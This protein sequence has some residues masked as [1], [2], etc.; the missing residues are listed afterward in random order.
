MQVHEES[1][2]IADQLF[3]RAAMGRKDLILDGTLKTESVPELEND[4]PTNGALGRIN[5]LKA[6]GYRVEIRFV[7]VDVETSAERAASRFAET[8]RLLPPLFLRGMAATAPP[9][10]T[11]AAGSR[12]TKPRQTFEKVKHLADAYQVIN[13]DG[14]FAPKKLVQKGKLT[15]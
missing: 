2:D 10:A 11:Q 14:D 7:D 15:P 9:P 12:T 8:E 5:F 6:M 1:A 4:D 13:N 3:V